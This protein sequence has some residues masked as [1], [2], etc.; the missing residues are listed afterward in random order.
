[1]EIRII[2]ENKRDYLDLLLLADPNLAMLERYLDRG[3]LFALFD[4]DLKTVAVV[5]G[6]SETACELKNLATDEKYQGR[7]YAT[8]LVRHVTEHYAGKFQEMFVG[9]GD[10]AKILRFYEKCGFSFSHVVK[11]FFL[12]NC[13]EPIYEDGVLLTDMIYLQKELGEEC[14]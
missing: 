10:S 6:E 8:R 14:P 7:G 1:M 2:R 11:N 13:P 3:E 12:D 5:T 9:T 4:P